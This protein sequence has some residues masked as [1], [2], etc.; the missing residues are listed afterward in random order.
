LS[1][2]KKKE[3]IRIPT[4]NASTTIIAGHIYN[5]KFSS[6]IGEDLYLTSFEARPMKEYLKGEMYWIQP[7]QSGML[8]V[9]LKNPEKRIIGRAKIGTTALIDFSSMRIEPA[10]RPTELPVNVIKKYVR[11]IMKN[12]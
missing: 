9:F 4:P 10:S 11:Y 8:P 12:C 3:I 1:H 7:I 6:L 2:K 5:S